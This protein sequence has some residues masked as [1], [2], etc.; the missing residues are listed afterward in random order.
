[1][2]NA[3]AK[4]KL[5]KCPYCPK[6]PHSLT[7]GLSGNHVGNGGTL[8]GNLGMKASDHPFS[9][10]GMRDTAQAHHL[11]C[12]EIMRRDKNWAKI[13]AT[14]GYDI[15]RK[16]NGVWLPGNMKVACKLAVPL[17]KSSHKATIGAL[18]R[19]NYVKSVDKLVVGIKDKAM[20][21]VD[22]YCKKPK[23][24]IKD[25]D[26]ASQEIWEEVEPFN[27]T[28]TKDGRH[29]KANSLIGCSG[30]GSL[31]K[32]ETNDKGVIINVRN[33]PSKRIHYNNRVIPKV[34]GR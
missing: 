22:N 27:W 26:E 15:N 23:Q 21:D 34:F 28:L 7:S 24:I 10:T 5:T 29:Y 8:G 11:I 18:P 2:A 1:M 16:E 3:V 4:P 30:Y 33:C 17:H 25:L 31:S 9:V 14:F 19:N 6:K 13:C 20:A 32:K 12:S